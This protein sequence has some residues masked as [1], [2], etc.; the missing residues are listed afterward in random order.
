MSLRYL[1]NMGLDSKDIAEIPG[2]TYFQRSYP[3]DADEAKI[4]W[5][6]L[7]PRIQH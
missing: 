4:I 3:T 1:D 2:L 6:A 7:I 5:A